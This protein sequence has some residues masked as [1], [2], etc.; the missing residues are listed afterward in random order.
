MV[1]I[2]TRRHNI[3]PVS[4]NNKNM[5]II[6]LVDPSGF[7][8][9]NV[10]Q[11]IAPVGLSSDCLLIYFDLNMANINDTGSRH[12]TVPFGTA[13]PILNIINRLK[14]VPLTREDDTNI[15]IW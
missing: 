13:Q 14:T 3:S 10:C 1:T 4:V 5:T 8:E 11:I 2:E 7:L 6:V 15:E 12:Q 9:Q